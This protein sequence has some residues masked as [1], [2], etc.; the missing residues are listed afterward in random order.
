[1]VKAKDKL[2]ANIEIIKEPMG[3]DDIKNYLGVSVPII[4]YSQL[5]N[6]E[7]IEDILPNNKTYVILLYESELNSGHWVIILRY[8]DIIEYFD[9]YGYEVDN[10]INWIDEHKNFEL[11]QDKKFL[12]ELLDNYKGKVI[13]NPIDYQV[14]K[15]DINTC[16]RHCVVRCL[17]N[18]KFNFNLKEY[19]NF[20]KLIKNKLNTNYDIIVSNLIDKI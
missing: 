10:P 8:N 7:S 12:S 1:M 3:D 18:R 14:L 20:M 4:K 5:E 16:G 15:N 9:P 11:G 6:F 2:K 17:M 13:Y 19:Y